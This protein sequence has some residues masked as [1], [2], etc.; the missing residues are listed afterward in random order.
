MP[1]VSSCRAVVRL[2]QDRVRPFLNRHP[3]VFA[4]AIDRISGN[5]QA[6]DE[7][8]VQTANGQF[9][10]R[11]LYNPV[12]A[13]RVRLYLWDEDQSLDE[14]F[15]RARLESALAVRAAAIDQAATDACRLVFSEADG[16]SGLI[17][18]RYSDWLLVQITSS[19][20]AV[21]RE[22]LLD[23]LESIVRPRGIVVRTDPAMQKAEGLELTEGLVRGS[24]PPQ[25][26]TIRENGLP[27]L[28]DLLEGQKTG[29]FLDQRDNRLA[30]AR[31]CAGASVLDAFC[32]SGGFGITAARCGAA[33]SV[34]CVDSSAPALEL[35]RRN[36]EASTVADRMQFVRSDVF[37][38]LEEALAA[39][40][41]F[42][43]V[44]LDPPKMARRQAAIRDALR[45]YHG[46]NVLGARLVKPGGL[47]VTCSCS[48][49]VSRADF[50]GVLAEVSTTVRRPLRILEARGHAPDHP[51]SP[52]CPESEYLKCFVCR[53]D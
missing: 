1:P 30:T 48:G 36:A 31:Y 23:L 44:I 53:L 10:A 28:V 2:K 4:G 17:V 47:L 11:G 33:A 19:A 15:W 35:A 12:S 51:V 21:R 24:A 22:L 16:L 41:R 6:G 8:L 43:V 14:A 25:P 5:P 3:W 38:Y 45:G 34:V 37:Q 49:L 42:D 9:V 32:Y 27:F 18:D 20:L 52:A 50:I 40:I 39:G 13:I 29:A 46:L 7:L 26:L